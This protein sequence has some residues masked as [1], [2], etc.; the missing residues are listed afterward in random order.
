M[1]ELIWNSTIILVPNSVTAYHL[2]IKRPIRKDL[3]MSLNISHLRHGRTYLTSSSNCRPR[4]ST[5]SLLNIPQPLQQPLELIKTPRPRD[6]PDRHLLMLP[7]P[8]LRTRAQMLNRM[9][10]YLKLW[11]QQRTHLAVRCAEEQG[12]HLAEELA[13]GLERLRFGLWSGGRGVIGGGVPC[14]SVVGP[15]LGVFGSFRVEGLAVELVRIGPGME[16]ASEDGCVEVDGG[17]RGC[18]CCADESSEH[19]AF[20]MCWPWMIDLFE[21]R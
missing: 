9:H 15:R 8:P 14:D 20:S 19:C 18:L 21:V 11:I 3:T 1:I 4:T 2:Q 6:L 10:R 13:F 16:G 7:R 12:I 17:S 5:S